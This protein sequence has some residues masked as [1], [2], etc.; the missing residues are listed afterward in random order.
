MNGL[1]TNDLT[2]KENFFRNIDKLPNELIDYIKNFIPKKIFVFTN[3]ENYNLYHVFLKPHINNYENYIR[4]TIRR[5]NSFVFERIVLHNFTIWKKI[6]NYMYRNIIFK[7]YLY[8]IIHYCIENDSNNCKNIIM[9]FLNLHGFDKNLH[10][11]N[12]VKYIRW[13]N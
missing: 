5:D 11:K 13:K 9:K 7:N 6:T 10:K 1:T 3:R 8:F 2:K 12:I 4:D